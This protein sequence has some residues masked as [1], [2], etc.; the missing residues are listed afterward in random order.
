MPG[1]VVE[2]KWDVAGMKRLDATMGSFQGAALQKRVE[3]TMGV[4]VKPLPPAIRVAEE[5]SGIAN[6]TGKHLKGI[7]ARKARKRPGEIAAWTAGPSGNTAHLLIDGH[8][9]VTH[10]GVDTGFRARDFPYVDPVVDAMAPE[11]VSFME[12]AEFAE[13]VRL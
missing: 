7:K 11:I 4:A 3:K 9:V 1:V 6:R 12:S 8:N 2:V 5:A 13:A 10:L